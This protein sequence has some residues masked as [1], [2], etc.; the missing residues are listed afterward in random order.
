MRLKSLV[1]LCVISLPVFASALVNLR[2]STPANN[3]TVSSPVSFSASAT[4]NHPIT[5][6]RI[7]VDNVA[8]YHAGATSS[9]K[10]SLNVSVGTHRVV[11]RAWASDGTSGSANLTETVKSSTSGSPEGAVTPTSL[12]FGSVATDATSSAKTVQVTNTGSATLNITGISISPSEFVVNGPVSTSIAPGGSV[13]Y[14]VTFT[15]PAVSSYSGTLRFATNSANAVAAVTLSGTGVDQSG[16]NANCSANTYYVSNAGNDGNAGV[17]ASSPWKT[18]AK[19]VAFEASLRPGD[20]V[21]FQRGG[22][23]SEQLSISNVHGNQSYPV[24]FGNYG[25]GNLPVI[26]GGSTRLYGIVGAKASGQAANSYVTINGFEVRNATRGGIIFSYLPQPGITIENNYVH[27]TGY[28]AYSGAPAGQYQVDDNQ[29]GYD[30]GISIT[31][32]PNGSY[33]S[34]ISNNMV[35]YIGGHNSVMV[36]NDRGN[37]SVTGNKI[38]PG[39]SHNC[40]DFKR[41]QGMTVKRNIINCSG[42]VNINGRTYPSCNGNAYYAQQDDSGYTLTGTFEQNVAYG[43][44]SGYGCFEGIGKASPLSLKLL[45]NTCYGGS[46]GALGLNFSS[47]GGGAFTIK[48]NIFHGANIRMDSSCTTG[49]WDYNDKYNSSGGTTG[50]HDMNANP[51]FINPAGMDFHLQPGSPVL[52]SGDSGVLG[53]SYIGA[54]GTSG[55]CP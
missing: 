12:A 30:E 49:I 8:L 51:A 41:S 19:V 26:D 38:G 29:Y 53:L 24:T 4:A 14:N 42:T 50:T 23:W 17:S 43:A 31:H 5:G 44:Y 27:N 46:T 34:K 25:S 21:L 36:D 13:T 45:N 33:G 40:F 32:Y 47:C 35:N 1:V 6:W 54:C 39:C 37:P 10:T 28:G 22:V 15:P 7:Y 16:T 48:N 11:I 18:V 2:V 52:N 20:C 55:N 9:I 3:S